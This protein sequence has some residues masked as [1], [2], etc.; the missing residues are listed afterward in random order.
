M[1][2]LELEVRSKKQLTTKIVLRSRRTDYGHCGQPP[3]SQES[4]IHSHYAAV[5]PTVNIAARLAAPF[6]CNA[7]HGNK[8]LAAQQALSR[9]YAVAAT[10][11]VISTISATV[12]LCGRL[13]NVTKFT[14][15]PNIPKYT[16]VM[17][18]HNCLFFGSYNQLAARARPI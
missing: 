13:K 8:R 7:D 10:C 1:A 12:N 6:A 15:I 9:H 18:N 4:H 14:N 5:R 16:K 2:T 11:S 17:I 3:C